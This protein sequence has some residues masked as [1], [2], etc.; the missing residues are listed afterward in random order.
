MKSNLISAA[1]KAAPSICLRSLSLPLLALALRFE[2]ALIAQ[3]GSVDPTFDPGSWVAGEVQTLALQAD[4]KVIVGGYLRAVSGDARTNLVRLSPDG[5]QDLT[6]AAGTG[7]VSDRIAH[8]LVQPDGQIVIAGRFTTVNGTTRRN[9]ARLNPNGSVDAG[10]DAGD[11]P[12]DA[13]S[14][15]GLQPDGQLLVGGLFT[16]FAGEAITNL[17]R[18]GSDGRLDSNFGRDLSLRGGVAPEDRSRLFAVAVQADGR[19]LIGGLFTTVNGVPRPGLARLNA[20]GTLDRSFHANFPTS[21]IGPPPAVRAMAALDDGKWL[22]GGEY[23]GRWGP[24]RPLLVRLGPDGTVDPSFAPLDVFGPATG[25]TAVGIQEHGR[26]VAAAYFFVDVFEPSPRVEKLVRRLQA[27]GRPDVT[28]NGGAGVEIE[29]GP[30]S[31]MP[32]VHAMVLQDDGRLLIGG[33]FAR[34][35]GVPRAGLARLNG[36]SLPVLS[37]PVIAGTNVSVSVTTETNQTYTL[38]YKDALSDRDWTSALGFSGD[39]TAQ[40]IVDPAGI[41]T[42]RFYRVVSP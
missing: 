14:C 21:D 34:V 23:F 7:D 30:S 11:G 2:L 5:S 29:G 26:V 8:V 16:A 19:I 25:I 33:A 40:T 20:D 3:P 6:F 38:Q 28:F 4:G 36:G 37:A 42:Q 12:N 35:S 17:A 41:R 15:L 18:V 13:L 9:L 10:F 31:H 1:V 39:G 32:W 24:S 22:V 27:D